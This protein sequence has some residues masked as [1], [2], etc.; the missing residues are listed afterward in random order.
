MNKY[1]QQT[2]GTIGG[3]IVYIGAGPVPQV[4]TGSDTP[5][6]IGRTVQYY[7]NESLVAALE[8]DSSLEVYG[9]D[10]TQDVPQKW[11]GFGEYR[12][13]YK[14]RDEGLDYLGNDTVVRTYASAHET[15]AG[16]LT[17]DFLHHTRFRS[18]TSE[19]PSTSSLCGV[20]QSGNLEGRTS[21]S[22][23]HD[24]GRLRRGPPVPDTLPCRGQ[25]YTGG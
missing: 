21:P 17:C 14:L 25:R 8:S 5:E 4:E 2:R 20:F 22:V 9:T 7:G 24:E 23:P 13:V 6:V 12:V 19:L 15:R 11:E 3:P 16:T 1:S 18:D 10:G